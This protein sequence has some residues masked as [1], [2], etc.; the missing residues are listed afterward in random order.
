M[1]NVLLKD[2]K[3]WNFWNYLFYHTDKFNLELFCHSGPYLLKIFATFDSSGSWPGVRNYFFCRWG[4]LSKYSP[5]KTFNPLL[6]FNQALLQISSAH[7]ISPNILIGAKMDMKNCPLFEV[8]QQY[9]ENLLISL[10][11][12]F[13]HIYTS[14]YTEITEQ[15][16]LM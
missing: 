1:K 9:N 15:P 16:S 13:C 2:W 11:T 4:I 10:L 7:N 3:L 6:L 5:V 12:C 14:N 8:T